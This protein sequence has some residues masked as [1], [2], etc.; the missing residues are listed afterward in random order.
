MKQEREN[1]SPHPEEDEEKWPVGQRLFLQLLLLSKVTRE[2]RRGGAE[3]RR[4]IEES[5]KG[6]ER[7]PEEGEESRR[8]GGER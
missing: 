8:E 2:W 5:R 3:V 6:N 4:Q 7:R 1:V